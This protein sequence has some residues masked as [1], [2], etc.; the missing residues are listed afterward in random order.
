MSQKL[1][2]LGIDFFGFSG[3]GA[4]K[5]S[6]ELTSEGGGISVR[7]GFA[8][9]PLDSR[10]WLDTCDTTAELS[11]PMSQ[12]RAWIAFGGQRLHSNNQNRWASGFL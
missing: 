10:R 2:G 9:G 4:K 5:D 6:V 3:V 7:Q 8:Q 11:Q 1:G 12:R